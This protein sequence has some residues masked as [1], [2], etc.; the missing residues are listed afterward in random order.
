ML[1]R[2]AT[3]ERPGEPVA[4]PPDPRAVS[5]LDLTEALL[6]PDPADRPG[7]AE[8]VLGALAAGLPDELAE[9]DR[10]W[11]SWMDVLE[12]GRPEADAHIR[13]MEGSRR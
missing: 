8:E 4:R 10:P 5:V 9:E 3:G 6:R 1:R 11:P 7:T 2:L 13:P 12:G